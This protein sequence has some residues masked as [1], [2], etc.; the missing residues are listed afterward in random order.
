MSLILDYLGDAMESGH[1]YE[2]PGGLGI[3][4]SLES[5]VRGAM[6]SAFIARARA[7]A[8]S[9][10]AAAVGEGGEEAADT[11]PTLRVEAQSSRSTIREVRE[12]MTTSTEYWEVRFA[13][14]HIERTSPAASAEENGEMRK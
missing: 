6:Q 5:R 1:S 3:S 2:W 13:M 10:V 4:A 9:T 11:G 14:L 12:F 8:L 7:T